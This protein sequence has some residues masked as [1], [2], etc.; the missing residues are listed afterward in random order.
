MEI[1]SLTSQD[2]AH[3]TDV[4]IKYSPNQFQCTDDTHGIP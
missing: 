1:L 2:F 3:A 4:H